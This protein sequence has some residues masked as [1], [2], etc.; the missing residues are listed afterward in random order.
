MTLYFIRHGKTRGN[1]EKRYIGKT[2]EPLCGAGRKALMKIKY[3]DAASVVSSPLL[4]CVETAKIIYPEKKPII[5]DD[6]RECDFGRFEGKNYAELNGTREYQKWIDSMGEMKFPEGESKAEF[7]E[8]VI[9][10]FKGIIVKCPDRAAFIV[11]GGAIMALLERFALPK[12]EFYDYYAE[13]GHG[14]EVLFDGR[15]MKITRGI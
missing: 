12:R 15:E 3:P 4:R 1:L 9:A 7:S 8:R 11:H 2:D 13:N 5:C 6:L 10:A 14:Y